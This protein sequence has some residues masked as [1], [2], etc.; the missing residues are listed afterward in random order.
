MSTPNNSNASLFL[1]GEHSDLEIECRGW[2]FKAHKSVLCPQSD[3]F[4]VAC[5]GGFKVGLPSHIHACVLTSGFDE[6]SSRGV[7]IEGKLPRMLSADGY[8]NLQNRSF[9][10][11]RRNPQL[12]GGFSNPYI[13]VNTMSEIQAL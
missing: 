7:K 5:N 10:S 8:R 6:N 11:P 12:Y 3:F 2:T 9:D 1:S 4:M 13:Q